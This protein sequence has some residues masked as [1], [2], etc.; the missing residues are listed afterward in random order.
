MLHAKKLRNVL[1]LLFVTLLSSCA[2]VPIRNHEWCG[3]F[4]DDGASCFNTQN[5]NSR[6]L[7][8]EEW[9][10]ERFSMLCTSP[11]NF[12]EIQAAILKLCTA[13]KRCTYDSK[14]KLIALRNKFDNHIETV[15]SIDPKL[16]EANLFL[17]QKT[18]FYLNAND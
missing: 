18:N 6:D 7:T 12:A 10:K 11:T 9:D 14:K 16:Y 1:L 4:G 15:I 13:T 5:D 3:D 2:K 17:T 8:K